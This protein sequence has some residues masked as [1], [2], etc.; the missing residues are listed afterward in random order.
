MRDRRR[1]VRALVTRSFGPPQRLIRLSDPP[2][3][4]CLPRHG[5]RASLRARLRPPSRRGRSAHS[6]PR[7]A[8]PVARRSL[9]LLARS[10]SLNRWFGI[11]RRCRCCVQG[12]ASRRAVGHPH[13][14]AKERGRR[15]RADDPSLASRLVHVVLGTSVVEIGQR[16][17][18]RWLS[19]TLD[20]IQVDRYMG[21]RVE[22]WSGPVVRAQ[23]PPEQ[24]SAAAAWKADCDDA[25]GA[26]LRPVMDSCP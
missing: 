16:H 10:S 21:C 25:A 6:L 1:P 15:S 4:T 22:P 2:R 20:L 7:I 12:E 17:R 14:S 23:Q 13:T 19:E 26:A 11:D 9:P 3:A 24:L 8:P 5:R 18:N